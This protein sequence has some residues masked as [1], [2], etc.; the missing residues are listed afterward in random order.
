M[1][2]RSRAGALALSEAS[3][4]RTALPAPAAKMRQLMSWEF[5]KISDARRASTILGRAR[6]IPDVNVDGMRRPQEGVALDVEHN[7]TE[8]R[9][10]SALVMCDRVSGATAAERR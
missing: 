9:L 2:N 8:M 3:S 4:A 5:A 10:A 7:A 6:N 1:R